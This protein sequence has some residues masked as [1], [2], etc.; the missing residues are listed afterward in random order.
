[1]ITNNNTTC[2]A[3]LQVVFFGTY[4]QQDKSRG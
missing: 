1:M 2:G 3:L 4:K